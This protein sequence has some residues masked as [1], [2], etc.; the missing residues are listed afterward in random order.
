[1]RKIIA[2][3]GPTPP[4]EAR[5]LLGQMAAA[6]AH[7]HGRGVLH[8]D[9]KPSNVLV[10]N[11]GLAKLVDFG[12]A[13]L[14]ADDSCGGWDGTPRY[15]PPEQLAA[16]AT[17]PA[18]D[19]YAW[20]CLAAELL[21]GRPLFDDGDLVALATAKSSGS[22]P[23]GDRWTAADPELAAIV[24]AALHPLPERRRLDLAGVARWAGPVSGLVPR[25]SGDPVNR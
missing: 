1:L 6:L 8:L 22:P 12:L 20:G 3:R 14:L 23:L 15:M 4:A 24:A 7:A 21:S 16:G 18:A 13:R 2:A 5:K 17:G 25:A 10:D 11:A 9:V 19:W